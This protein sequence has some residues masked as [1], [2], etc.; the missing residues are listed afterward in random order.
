MAALRG[1][2][3]GFVLAEMGAHTANA[4]Q[5]YFAS[6]TPDRHDIVG[7]RLDLEGS[8]LRELEEETG[9]APGEVSLD[10]GWII[11]EAGA[12]YACMKTV[13][14]EAPAAEVA[15]DLNAR[16][17]AQSGAELAGVRAVAS[18]RD[19][20]RV[21]MPDFIVAYLESAFGAAQP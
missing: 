21:R 10:P 5:I 17:A 1:A 11:V 18:A 13:R 2:D 12:R 16:I 6:G 19:I 7:G 20:D 9:L 8:V 3:G 4:G 15:R 14:V